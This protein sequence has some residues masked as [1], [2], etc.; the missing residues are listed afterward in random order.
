MEACRETDVGTK[1]RQI[2][3]VI[4]MIAAGY[5]AYIIYGLYDPTPTF[6][7]CQSQRVD[8]SISSACLDLLKEGR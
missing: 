1:K 2:W 3:N 5:A 6:E 8:E 7:E 4:M